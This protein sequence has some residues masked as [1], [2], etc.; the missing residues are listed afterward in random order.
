MAPMALVAL[1]TLGNLEDARKLARALV[2]ARLVACATLLPGATS[3]YRW[4]GQITEEPEVVVL[5]KTEAA[6]WEALEAAV[7]EWHPYRVPELV[8]MPVDRG[9]ESYLRWVEREVVE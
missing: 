3:V 9:L 6:K 5:L 8:A 4:E 1:T 2:D 7:R